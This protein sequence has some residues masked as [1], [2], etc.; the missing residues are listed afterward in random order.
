[1]VTWF[2]RVSGFGDSTLSRRWEASSQL[3]I[4]QCQEVAIDHDEAALEAS[5]AP[6][7]RRIIAECSV[8]EE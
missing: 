2:W 6:K 7:C 8:T 4:E 5:S 3:V 1:M